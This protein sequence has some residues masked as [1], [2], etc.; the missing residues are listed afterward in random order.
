MTYYTDFVFTLFGLLVGSFLNVV[1]Y[2][3]PRLM[4]ITWV[5]SK[6]TSCGKLIY[7]YENIP[8]ISYLFLRGKCSSCKSKISPR[9]PL[10]EL[11]VACAAWILAPESFSITSI[12]YFIFGFGVFCILL[13]QFMIDLDHKLLMDS[14]NIAL[15][16]FFIVFS[17]FHFSW[18][19]SLLGAVVGFVLPYGVTWLFY[20][21]RGVV[22]LGGGD[23]KL[24]CVLGI[25]LGAQGVI[26]NMVF[27]CGLGAIIGGGLLVFKLIKREEPI[28]FGP[29]I[30]TIAAWQIY[31]PENFQKM[32]IYIFG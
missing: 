13:S 18:Q 11:V 28:P 30:I 23:I 15:A 4:S 2:R 19:F 3:L 8:V 31:Y 26:H 29:F 9:Y 12:A 32:I 24:F 5:R 16:L 25:Y 20:V 6:C 27:S 1:I 17:Y 7:W 10:I 14:L 22:G 21:L